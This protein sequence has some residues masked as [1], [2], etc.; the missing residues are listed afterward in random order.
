MNRKTFIL[1]L[2]IAGF[3][4]IVNGQQPVKQ[5]PAVPATFCISQAEMKLYRMINEYRSRYDLPPVP[6]SKSLSYVAKMH[7]RDLFLYHPDNGACNAHSWSARGPWKPFCYPRD[8]NK[9]NS[10]W[11]KP[12]EITKYPG[13]AYEIVYWENNPVTIDSVFNVW[14]SEDYFVDFLLNSGKWQDK[15]WYAIGIG[16]HENYACAW[17][18]EMHDPEGGLQVC[19]QAVEPAVTN[20]VKPAKDSIRE[21]KPVDTIPGQAGTYYIIIRSGVP[22]DQA[23]K[24]IA[25]LKTKGYENPRVLEK[26]GKARISVFET[27]D[28]TAAM[29]RLR[30]IKKTSR[31]AWLLKL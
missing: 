15:K 30:E 17:F 24:V 26:D 28:K 2:M 3:T 6:L 14:K 9:K 11:D 5:G 31:D 16:I 18:G 8:E 12:R 1:C 20:T 13:K 25:T 19:G 22:M 7:A 23:D 4:T 10:V 21:M 29:A 27:T